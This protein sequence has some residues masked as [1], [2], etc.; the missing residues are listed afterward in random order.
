M[1]LLLLTAA[2]GFADDEI[3]A[4]YQSSPNFSNAIGTGS[5]TVT[6]TAEPTTL[7]FGNCIVF[8]LTIDRVRNPAKVHRP[9]LE[10]TGFAVNRLDETV[11]DQRVVF[12]YQLWPNSTAVTEIPSM[13]FDYYYPESA[14]EMRL[15]TKYTEAIPIVVKPKEIVAPLYTLPERFSVPI[16]HD[17]TPWTPPLGA[18]IAAPA[19]LAILAYFWVYIWRM[20]NPQGARLAALQRHQAVRHAVAAIQRA[21]RGGD[22]TGDVLK[23]FQAYLRER[24]NVTASAATPQELGEELNRRF[25]TDVATPV[26]RL[27]REGDAAR[28]GGASAVDFATRARDAI[29]AL[30]SAS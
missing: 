8:T 22:P 16:A 10:R 18:W 13:R 23:A 15:R 27:L 29:L 12:R 30:E 3:P 25:P 6:A 4:I 26:E 9:F 5:L 24:F 14:E 1:L 28:F 20:V 19:L 21:E 7:T 11:G 17:A 2:L